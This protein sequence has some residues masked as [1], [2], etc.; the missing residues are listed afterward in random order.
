[1]AGPS[2]DTLR[3]VGR[4]TTDEFG[5]PSA[6]DAAVGV[7]LCKQYRLLMTKGFDHDAM[8]RELHRMV[9]GQ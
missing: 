9:S 2:A 1:M 3:L 5:R 4:R 6:E 8:R 7:Y